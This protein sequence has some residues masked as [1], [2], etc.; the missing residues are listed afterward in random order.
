VRVRILVAAAFLLAGPLPAAAA[1]R[2]A[3]AY[4]ERKCLAEALYFEAASEGAEGMRAVAEVVFRRAASRDFPGTV[5][6]VVYQGEVK[7]RCHFSFACDGARRRAR[8]RAIWRQSWRLAG[9]WLKARVAVLEK[10]TT[11]DATHFHTV[12][13]APGW[14]RFGLERTVQIGR[15]IFYR[16]TEAWDGRGP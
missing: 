9:E 13:V 3:L 14:E 5:C 15:H 6:K 7:R 16:P 12:D 2:A 10:N 8:G 4:A 1:D 11:A